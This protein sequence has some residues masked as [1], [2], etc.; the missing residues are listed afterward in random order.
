MIKRSPKTAF[1]FLCAISLIAAWRPL[2]D[3]LWLATH[4]EEYTHLLLILPAAAAM[5]WLKLSGGRWRSSSGSGSSSPISSSLGSTQSLL[6]PGLGAGLFLL[7]ISLLIAG[8]ARWR[9]DLPQDE[10]LTANM[11]ALVV[12]WVGS[13]VLCFGTRLSR[14][15]LFPL[16]FLLLVVPLPRF[17]LD[18]IVAWLQQASAFAA[19]CMFSIARVPVTQNGVLLDI[20]GLTVEVAKECSSIRSSSMLLVTTMILAQLLL[21][22]SW[23]KWL[24]ILVAIPVSVAKNGLRIFTIAML[25]TRVDPSYLTGKLHHK[26]GIVFF[27]IGLGCMF[28]VLWILQRNERASFSPMRDPG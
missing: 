2:R 28:F 27:S 25:G 14:S 26:G 12:W 20:P 4:D 24:A 13:F 5:I 10:R 6:A 3:T 22:T 1:L 23:R 16:G 19:H 17:L 15:L 7:S 21:R 18:G 11:L 9:T 8:F